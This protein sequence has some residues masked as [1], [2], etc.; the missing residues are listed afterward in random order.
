MADE[1]PNPYLA[2]IRSR[3]GLAVPVAA[4]L[5]DDLDAVVRAMDA[6]AWV[7]SAADDFYTDLT[8]HRRSVT[9]ASDG[10]IATFDDAIRRQPE[11]VEPGAWQTRWRNLR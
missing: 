7:S 9:T 2:A 10:A 8:G 4:D 11:K 1:I 6:G 5:R 3:R